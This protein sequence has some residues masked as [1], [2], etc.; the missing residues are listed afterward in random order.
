VIKKILF[1]VGKH[2]QHVM[3]PVVLSAASEGTNVFVC[4]MI[5]LTT[6]G[7][8]I[9]IIWMTDSDD[10]NA[11]PQDE[12]VARGCMTC[13]SGAVLLACVMLLFIL[14]IWDLD[15]YASKHNYNG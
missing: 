2:T 7:V 1:L 13:F 11:L 12:R 3:P 6:M 4:Y 10:D 5:L 8:S 14:G 15:H 9:I